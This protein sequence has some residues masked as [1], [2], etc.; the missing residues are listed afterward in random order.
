MRTDIY[1]ITDSGR[2][3]PSN[4][5]QVTREIR[6]VAEAYF[7]LTPDGRL[8]IERTSPWWVFYYAGYLDDY[9]WMNR[10]HDLGDPDRFAFVLACNLSVARAVTQMMARCVFGY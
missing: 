2:L 7:G 6:R 8:D 9:Q 10:L 4:Y 1:Y 3:Y 5:G